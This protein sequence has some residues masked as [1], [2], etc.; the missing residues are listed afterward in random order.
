MFVV[1][2]LVRRAD[3][4]RTQAQSQTGISTFST[5]IVLHF[6]AALFVS[7]FLSAPLHSFVAAAVVLGVGGLYGIG[8]V[9]Y[10]AY[11][12]RSLTIYTADP[13]DWTWYIILP[14]LA[15]VILAVGAVFLLIAPARA[16]FA[17]AGGVVLLVL[18]GV[19][20]AW[21]IVTYIASGAADT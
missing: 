14:L 8:Y 18:V 11:R 15:Y 6:A 7:L 21:D 19:R 17:L 10:I 9:V 4:T 16:L 20:N 1:I 2:T 12:T 5:P 13:E 3:R